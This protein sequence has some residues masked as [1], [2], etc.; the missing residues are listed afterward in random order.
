LIIRFSPCQHCFGFRHSSFGFSADEQFA[1]S[2]SELYRWRIRAAHRRPISRQHRTGDGKAYSQVADSD[3]RDV[4]LAVKAAEKAF[5]DWSRKP[6]EERSRILLCIA[7]L[8]ERDLEK[9]ARAES[10]DTGKP[11]SL[12]R[13]L[14]IEIFGPVI[15]IT[16][17]D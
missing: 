9:F 6:A 11:L 3:G 17:F 10:I 13:S 4:D 2:Y 15:T 16:P 8:I 12:A 14:D 1:N 5:A 7:D